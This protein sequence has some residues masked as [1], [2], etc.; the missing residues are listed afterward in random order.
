MYDFFLQFFFF[1]LSKK[2]TKISI[3]FCFI[4]SYDTL[5]SAPAA[6]KTVVVVVVVVKLSLVH[7]AYPE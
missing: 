6:P 2:L 4:L 1:S 5:S 3:F 7:F